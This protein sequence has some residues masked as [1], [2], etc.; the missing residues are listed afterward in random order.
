MKPE[1]LVIAGQHT[2]VNVFLTSTTTRNTIARQTKKGLEMSDQKRRELSFSNWE[3]VIADIEKL[4]SSEHE[5]IGSHSFGKI[6]QHLAT[7]NQMVVGNITPPKLPWFM[8]LAMP[9]LKKG[10]LSN[11]VEPG[12][13]LPN[14][15]MQEFFWS[16]TDVDPKEAVENFRAS[17][18]VYKAKG[19]LAVHP[20]FG[21]ATKEQVEKLTL[22]HATM[23]LSF[24]NPK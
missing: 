23:H 1:S 17:V 15:A 5:T 13:K 8:R 6:V 20:I 22:S 3:E 2:T 19:P 11:P 21:K 9:F 4:A 18:E 16:Q 24:V 10:I 12:F 14:P 7:T